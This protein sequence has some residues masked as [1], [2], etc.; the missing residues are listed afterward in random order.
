V[1]NRADLLIDALLELSDRD[2]GDALLLD[3]DA[4][5][6]SLTVLGLGLT[7]VG[8][9]VRHVFDLSMPDAV[10][11][12]TVAR[13]HIQGNPY[14]CVRQREAMR[15]ARAQEPLDHPPVTVD[16]MVRVGAVALAFG[17]TYRV[18]L[19]EDGVT[20]ESDTDHTVM[21]GWI[22]CLIASRLD[23]YD[24]GR[25]AQFALVHDLPEALVGDT[26]SFDISDEARAEKEQREQQAIERLEDLFNG[27]PWLM[28]TL[29]AYEEQRELEARLVRY[30]D[31]IMPKITHALNGCAAIRS[32][33]KS[34]EDLQRSH[35]KQYAELG[36]A[37]PDMPEGV[38]KLLAEIMSHAEVHWESPMEHPVGEI[39]G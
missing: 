12:A 7:E 38:T 29:K 22:A 1:T 4:V 34:F 9:V 30:V 19:H 31:K 27:I 33:G 39:D 2:D 28:D 25:V 24:V 35:L 37:Y 11:R 36:E 23:V 17:R 10:H 15:Q 13:E 6:H 32:M 16:Q 20:P 21:L 8:W 3:A 14:G 18:T 5:V 26:N